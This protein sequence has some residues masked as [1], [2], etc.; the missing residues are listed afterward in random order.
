MVS[1]YD[2]RLFD[3]KRYAI[4]ICVC[5]FVTSCSRGS[6]IERGGYSSPLDVTPIVSSQK[7]D[8]EETSL[9]NHTNEP[10]D[11]TFPDTAFS[12]H[13]ICLYNGNKTA[14]VY[15]IEV[16]SSNTEKNTSCIETENWKYA[17][18]LLWVIDWS[19][20]KS[21]LCYSEPIEAKGE[22]HADTIKYTPPADIATK[23]I[24]SIRM[25]PLDSI[26][27]R[28]ELPISFNGD[29]LSSQLQVVCIELD[30]DSFPREACFA[31]G[32]T[33]Y[34]PENY[35]T[36]HLVGLSERYIDGIPVFGTM[37]II[38]SY[39]T[40]CVYEYGD[41]IGPTIGSNLIGSLTIPSLNQDYCIRMQSFGEYRIVDTVDERSIMSVTECYNGIKESAE[42][43]GL[44]IN[45]IQFYAAELAYLPLSNYDINSKDFSEDT[46]TFLIPVWNMYFL[47]G[48]SYQMGYCLTID[49]TTGKSLYSKEY[50]LKDERVFG[51]E[52]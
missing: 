22:I 40:D 44:S 41:L 34:F 21:F 3:M 4:V 8:A 51:N 39:P 46:R 19:F 7:S 5:L 35:N 6:D 33:P 16:E 12:D 38:A 10:N 37:G 32:E 49:A 11:D 9:N 27:N 15:E 20:G 50:N 26:P 29:D 31:P 48:G 23:T 14:L 36:V 17:Y 24:S 13:F 47:Y 42:Y 18:D 25:I 43:L 1:L 28:E 52:I 2:I 45:Q 30:G